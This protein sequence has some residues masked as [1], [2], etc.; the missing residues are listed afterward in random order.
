M[1]GSIRSTFNELTVSS[2]LKVAVS[3]KTNIA[4]KQVSALNTRDR[5]KHSVNLIN[6]SGTEKK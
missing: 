6:L 4:Y 5:E 2:C 1:R 3:S